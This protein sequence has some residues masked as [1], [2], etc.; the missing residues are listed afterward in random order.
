MTRE[1]PAQNR[2]VSMTTSDRYDLQTSPFYG[3]LA[4][5]V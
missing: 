3:I 1:G 2:Y 5:F 4:N